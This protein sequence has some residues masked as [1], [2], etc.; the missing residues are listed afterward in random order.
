MNEASPGRR[1]RPWLVLAG[2]VLVAALVT[3]DRGSDGPALDPSSTGPLGTRAL[4]LLLESF[5]AEVSLTGDA[6]GAGTGT[7]LLLVD[8]LGAERFD[9]LTRWV[10]AGGTLLVAD[11]RS[12]LAPPAEGRSTP[13]FGTG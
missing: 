9:A 6:P 12:R 1:A 7:A 13:L 4:V 3:G 5:G 10:R 2:A 8:D 11:P